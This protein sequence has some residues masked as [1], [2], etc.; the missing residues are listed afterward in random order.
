MFRILGPVG[1]DD[2][3]T[4]AA[5]SPKQKAI[6]AVLLVSGQRTVPVKQLVTE[7]WE[8]N[9]PESAVA[10]LRT[11]LSGLRGALTEN[12]I[13]TRQSGYLLRRSGDELD[14]ERFS[15]QCR[16]GRTALVERDFDR[17]VEQ[18][19]NALGLWRGR[20]L[21]DVPMGPTLRMHSISLEEQRLAATEDLLRANLG[22][23]DTTTVVAGARHII[24]WEPTRESAWYLL[25][26]GLRD[27]GNPAGALK[28]FRDLRTLLAS[29]LGIEPCARL[30]DLHTRILQRA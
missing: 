18:L 16:T 21:D 25:M 29:Q 3:T 2:D 14:A 28:A 26:L 9:P 1:M 20:A 11:Y 12:R 24:A 15:V 5:F 23:G 27:A 17:A 8:D 6:L 13:V 10:N 22:L 30:A 7:L 19:D 4:A